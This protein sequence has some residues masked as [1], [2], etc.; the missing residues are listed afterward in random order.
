MNISFYLKAWQNN[1]R[2][3]GKFIARVDIFVDGTFK[4][5]YL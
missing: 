3:D 1:E 4:I 2:V 5:Y